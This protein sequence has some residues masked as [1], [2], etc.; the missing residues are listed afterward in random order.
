VYA[1]GLHE[2]A[3]ALLEVAAG[4]LLYVDQDETAVDRASPYPAIAAAVA[5]ESATLGALGA[6]PPSP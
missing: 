5:P 3:P 2:A 6:F 4:S 1:V